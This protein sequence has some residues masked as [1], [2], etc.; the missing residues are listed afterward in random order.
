MIKQT[1]DR[2]L[3]YLAFVMLISQRYQT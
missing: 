3:S 2:N 1:T